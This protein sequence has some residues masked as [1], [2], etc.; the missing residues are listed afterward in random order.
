MSL[1]IEPIVDGFLSLL[2]ADG[3]TG[4]LPPFLEVLEGPGTLMNPPFAHVLPLRTTFPNRGEGNGRN[5]IHF[6]TL[7]LGVPGFDPQKMTRE[8]MAYVRAIDTAIGAFTGWPD[9]VLRAY[10]DTHDYGP[11]YSRDGGQLMYMPEIH[12]QVEVEEV[13]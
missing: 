12:C 13:S 9:Y 2:G 8:A 4:N 3:A 7:R 11:I 1:L 5:Q 6:V 10:M